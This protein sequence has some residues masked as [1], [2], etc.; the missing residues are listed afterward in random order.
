MTS[1]DGADRVRPPGGETRPFPPSVGCPFIMTGRCSGPGRGAAAR[2]DGDEAGEPGRDGKKTAVS[3]F[4]GCP[5]IMT[6]RCS[7]PARFGSVPEMPL[8][9]EDHGEADVV[10][11]ADDLVVTHR[12]AG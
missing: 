7:G 12:A 3:R 8:P 2:C 6:G 9:G 4:V 1:E 11:G 10:G 5:L